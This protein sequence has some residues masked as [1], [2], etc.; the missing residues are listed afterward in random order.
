MSPQAMPTIPPDSLLKTW[1]TIEQAAVQHLSRNGTPFAVAA[2]LIHLHVHPEAAEPAQLADA[3]VIPRQSMTFTIDALER[4]QLA[5]R[6]SHPADRRKK[7]IVLTAK[8]K[9][10][11]KKTLEDLLLFEERAFSSFTQDELKTFRLMLIK[12]MT[13]LPQLNT[14]GV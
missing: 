12:L 13:G 10:E 8:G 1:L 5:V 7:I 9:K 6:Q 11:A 2:S 3:L 4:S 14:K